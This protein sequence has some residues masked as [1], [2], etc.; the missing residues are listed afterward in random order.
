MKKQADAGGDSGD[1]DA[2]RNP[3][4]YSKAYAH[5]ETSTDPAASSIG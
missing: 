2:N 4:G 5:T 3:R 1:S